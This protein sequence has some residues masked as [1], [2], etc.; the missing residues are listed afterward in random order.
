[1]SYIHWLHWIICHF[2]YTLRS[3]SGSASADRSGI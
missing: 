3:P 2:V 1:L